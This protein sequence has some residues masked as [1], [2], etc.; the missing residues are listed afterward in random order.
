MQQERQSNNPREPIAQPLHGSENIRADDI[1][2]DG[3]EIEAHLQQEVYPDGYVEELP[4]AG[5]QQRSEPVPTFISKIDFDRFIGSP[6]CRGIVR[7]FSFLA[8]HMLKGRSILKVFIGL[9][10]HIEDCGQVYHSVRSQEN[11]PYSL[12]RMLLAPIMALGTFLAP[13]FEASLSFLALFSAVAFLAFLIMAALFAAVFK[14]VFQFIGKIFGMRIND[15]NISYPYV[16]SELLFKEAFSFLRHIFRP[17]NAPAANTAAPSPNAQRQMNSFDAISFILNNQSVSELLSLLQ[18]YQQ[19]LQEK[20]MSLND[21]LGGNKQ[22]DALMM[23]LDTLH[24][25]IKDN[26]R[27]KSLKVVSKA[28]DILLGTAGT[29]DSIEDS[30]QQFLEDFIRTTHDA[31]VDVSTWDDM[32]KQE[33]VAVQRSCPEF[34]GMRTQEVHDAQVP[35]AL[36]NLLSQRGGIKVVLSLLRSLTALH[37]VISQVKDDCEKFVRKVGRSQGRELAMPAGIDLRERIKQIKQAGVD[38]KNTLLDT[39]IADM[40]VADIDELTNPQRVSDLA[41]ERAKNTLKTKQ[42]VFNDYKERFKREF[43]QELDQEKGIFEQGLF[44]TI[45]AQL[46]GKKAPLRDAN[47]NPIDN[48]AYIKTI[49][50]RLKVVPDSEKNLLLDLVIAELFPSF[51]VRQDV[52]SDGSADAEDL[53]KREF[54]SQRAADKATFKR[55]FIELVKSD[56]VRDPVAIVG[57]LSPQLFNII[58]K[59]EHQDSFRTLVG[60]ILYQAYGYT[61]E[62]CDIDRQR[63]I[64]AE[65]LDPHLMDNPLPFDKPKWAEWASQLD[66]VPPEQYASIIDRAIADQLQCLEPLPLP[67]LPVQNVPENRQAAYDN[68]VAQNSERANER[69][70]FKRCCLMLLNRRPSQEEFVE[71][72]KKMPVYQKKKDWVQHGVDGEHF[73]DDMLHYILGATHISDDKCSELTKHIVTL[74]DAGLPEPDVLRIFE[75]LFAGKAPA[76]VVAGGA[77]NVPDYDDDLIADF[78]Q[79]SPAGLLRF[80]TKIILQGMPPKAGG[81]ENLNEQEH[82]AYQKD[83]EEIFVQR[84]WESMNT[85]QERLKEN[86]TSLCHGLA[87]VGAGAKY[88]QFP[89]LRQGLINLSGILPAL[90]ENLSGQD[91]PEGTPAQNCTSEQKLIR[92]VQ[93]LNN[94]VRQGVGSNYIPGI[95]QIAA[96]NRYGQAYGLGLNNV[97]PALVYAW[98]GTENGYG[99][100]STYTQQ[101]ANYT[102]QALTSAPAQINQVAEEV[103]NVVVQTTEA[104]HGAAQQTYQECAENLHQTAVDLGQG[105]NNVSNYVTG[106]ANGVVNNVASW[107]SSGWGSSYPQQ[108]FVIPSSSQNMAQQCPP[109]IGSTREQ[110]I[111]D[112]SKDYNQDFTNTLNPLLPLPHPYP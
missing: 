67:T 22:M 39:L 97:V 99:I 111:L 78:V 79:K 35:G 57:H 108:E 30:L 51:D 21:L 96:I 75:D 9:G 28:L 104:L 65:I 98:A 11:H 50:S 84:L 63:N 93:D 37:Y 26:P 102:T 72:I 13:F 105:W 48:A 24:D 8:K 53:A 18:S 14:N 70:K 19:N 36:Q 52:Q 10:G 100:A 55:E 88:G 91:V 66:K 85:P 47:N 32:T 101:A 43:L 23:L 2:Q 7:A 27:H 25:E 109:F 61:P 106:C 54:N 1:D 92:Y 64:N 38:E 77:H 82:A 17:R 90:L 40:L 49:L 95:D 33:Q 74:N 110:Q 58:R 112:F 20:E 3:P 41:D 94:V 87:D 29:T 16:F 5:E 34:I 42:K 69:A 46:Y 103:H 59:P 12:P 62:S 76:T 71:A 83:L 6:V 44:R 73:L 56:D 107:W 60:L 81:V 15:Q 68:I 4:D 80:A 45:K 86:L 89:R 31:A